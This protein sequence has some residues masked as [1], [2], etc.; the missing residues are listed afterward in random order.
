M[1]KNWY[2]GLRIKNRVSLGALGII[3]QTLLWL[4][5]KENS[6]EMEDLII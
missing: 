5:R 2:K 1:F 4:I 3:V 6:A